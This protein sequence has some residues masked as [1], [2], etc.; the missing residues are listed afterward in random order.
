M[1]LVEV[2]PLTP[3][4]QKLFAQTGEN[5]REDSSS[6]VREPT[7]SSIQIATVNVSPLKN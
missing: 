6:L 5:K 7:Q 2:V 3:S 1:D 4:K